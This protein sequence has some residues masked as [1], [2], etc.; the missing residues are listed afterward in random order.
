[1][2]SI[3]HSPYSVHRSSFFA[4]AFLAQSFL[5]PIPNRRRRRDNDPARLLVRAAVGGDRDPAVFLLGV[6]NADVPA[7]GVDAGEFGEQAA[8]VLAFEPRAAREGEIL[9]VGRP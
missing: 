1:M 8:Q 3:P 4:V 9:H 7:G 6:A 5:S 2:S